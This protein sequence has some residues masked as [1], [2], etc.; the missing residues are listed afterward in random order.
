MSFTERQKKAEITRYEIWLNFLIPLT[1]LSAH[2]TVEREGG[3]GG[4]DTLGYWRLQVDICWT[5]GRKQQNTNMNCN[6]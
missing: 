2:S 1:L 6:D 3:A 4:E 5:D